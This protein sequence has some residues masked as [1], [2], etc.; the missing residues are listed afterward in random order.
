VLPGTAHRYLADAPAGG[1]KR[2]G[3]Y[4]VDDTFHA[5]QAEARKA[6]RK[7]A[8]AGPVASA[9][10]SSALVGIRPVKKPKRLEDSATEGDGKQIAPPNSVPRKRKTLAAFTGAIAAACGL[11]CNRDTNHPGC[12]MQRSARQASQI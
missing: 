10:T 12:C 2:S 7:T 4:Y 6:W 11:S 3:S 1:L 9:V 5:E 8:T